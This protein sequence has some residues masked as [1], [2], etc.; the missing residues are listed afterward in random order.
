M[1]TRE[2]I[3]EAIAQ[4]INEALIKSYPLSGYYARCGAE[5]K[6]Q[7]YISPDGEMS[8]RDLAGRQVIVKIVVA[9]P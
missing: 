4:E 6:R 3:Q 7:C 2:Q 5:Q 1:P 8:W 9:E